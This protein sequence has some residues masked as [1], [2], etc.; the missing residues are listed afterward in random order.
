MTEDIT[1]IKIQYFSKK[2]FGVGVAVGVWVITVGVCV[3]SGGKH[4][5]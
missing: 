1:K 4:S 5:G 3:I 2:D